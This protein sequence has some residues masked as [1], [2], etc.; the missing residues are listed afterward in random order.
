[1]FGFFA[2]RKAR[3]RERLRSRPFPNEWREVLVKKFP[4]F[5]RLNAADQRELEGLIQVFFDEKRIEACGGFEM[6]DEVRVLIAAQACLLLLHRETDVYPDLKTV[7]VYPETYVVPAR[8]CEE[9]EAT[10]RAS[11]ARLGESWRRG[12]VVLSWS[13]AVAGAAN[14]HDGSNLVL[15]EF[16]HQLDQE[17]GAADGAPALSCEGLEGCYVRYLTWARV[18]AKEFEQLR[19]ETANG[20]KTLL[21]QYGATDPAEFFAVG[22]ECFFEKPR[23]MLRKHPELYAELSKFYRQD[24]AALE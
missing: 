11:R 3:R 21:D 6:K 23:Q 18:L 13:S 9:G 8:A 22:T 14:M 10:D 7:L 15:H 5:R 20:R 16:A 24:P 2:R 17:D 19:K 12:P 4:L 1:M